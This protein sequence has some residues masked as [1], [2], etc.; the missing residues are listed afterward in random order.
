MCNKIWYLLS[1]KK[2][3]T[4]ANERRGIS[5]VLFS[6]LKPFFF[7]KG[8]PFRINLFIIF[9]ISIK[10]HYILTFTSGG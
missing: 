5:V 6:E 1:Y 8:F 10:Q 3:F 9:I 4:T 2:T 7:N